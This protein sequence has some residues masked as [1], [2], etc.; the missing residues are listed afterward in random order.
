MKHSANYQNVDGV[1]ARLTDAAKLLQPPPDLDISEWADRYRVLSSANAL[2]GKYRTSVVPYAREP[3]NSICDPRTYRVSLMWGAQV[4]KTES[5]I[6]NTIG[7]YIHQDPKSIIAMHPTLADLRTWSETKLG[8]MLADCPELERRVAKPRGREGVN[9]ANMKSYPGGFLYLVTA[10]SASNLR[11]KSAPV[12]LCDEIDGYKDTG[13]GDPINLLWQRSATFG[14]QKKLIETSTPTIKGHSRI[15]DAYQA[16]DQR[17][18]FIPCPHCEESQP[19]KWSNVQWDKDKDG[20]HLTE[21]ARYE[22]DHCN[23]PINDGQKIAALRRGEWIA[24]RPFRGHASYHL[25]ELY[26]PFRKWSELVQSF[27]DKKRS[28]DLQAFTNVCLAETWEEEGEGADESVLMSRVKTYPATV[29]AGAVV[30]TCAVDVQDDR[31]EAI[32]EGWAEGQQNWKIAFHSIY[33]DLTKLSGPDSP[34]LQLDDFLN[35]RFEHESGVM[36]PIACTLIDSGGHFTPQVYKFCKPRESRRVYAIKGAS[37]SNGPII[38][39]PQKSTVNKATIWMINTY[40]AKQIIYARLKIEDEGAGYVHFPKGAPGF[41]PEYF[42]QLTAEKLV[43]RY[44]EGKRKLQWVQTRKR[45]E[46]LDLAVY[47]LAAIELLNPNYDRIKQNFTPQDGKTVVEPS[48]KR[49][50]RMA[51]PKRDWV[52]T[53]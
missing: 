21:T 51:R 27:L 5:L 25:S 38:S 50:S 1:R 37:V 26:S 41:D 33:G 20:T 29:P 7:Y 10:G 3:M 39:R 6:N 30:L 2:A 42:K 53:W 15:E 28:G 13:E 36:L 22:C 19:L 47:N 44:K 35:E 17:K 43:A 52:N 24:E 11:S 18:Y 4:G 40:A 32:V 14:D 48:Y 34:W 45:N 16:G 9:N 31:L 12:I 49:P 23:Q 8:P 46:A